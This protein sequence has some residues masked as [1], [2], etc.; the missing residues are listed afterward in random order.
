MG[1]H[2]TS[3]ICTTIYTTL[4]HDTHPIPRNESG[5]PMRRSLPP[6]L[7]AVCVTSVTLIVFAHL[8][9]TRRRKGCENGA[10][11]SE[12]VPQQDKVLK[13]GERCEK[14]NPILEGSQNNGNSTNSVDIDSMENEKREKKPREVVARLSSV[15]LPVVEIILMAVLVTLLVRAGA[16]VGQTS[17]EQVKS[18]ILPAEQV[19][20]NFQKFLRCILVV[21]CFTSAC[22]Q[23]HKLFDPAN[24][25]N[26]GGTWP[27]MIFSRLSQELWLLQSNESVG[28]TQRRRLTLLLVVLSRAVLGTVRS[29]IKFR[30][31]MNEKPEQNICSGAFVNWII[32]LLD[33]TANCGFLLGFT[34]GRHYFMAVEQDALDDPTA[35]SPM[36]L[37]RPKAVCSTEPQGDEGELS[38][39]ISQL[40]AKDNSLKAF[41]QGEEVDHGPIFL[42]YA[43]RG[44]L[45]LLLT[46]ALECW[47][48]SHWE[49][50]ILGNRDDEVDVFRMRPYFQSW[51]P[52]FSRWRLRRLI[53][54]SWRDLFY[55][56]LLYPCTAST[57]VICTFFAHRFFGKGRLRLVD[58]SLHRVVMGLM[59]YAVLLGAH[60]AYFAISCLLICWECRHLENRANDFARLFPELSPKQRWL[61]HF[62]LTNEVK[63]LQQR[64]APLI[65]YVFLQRLAY[66]ALDVARQSCDALLPFNLVHYLF[67]HVMV[68]T[69]LG[70]TAWRIGKLNFSIYEKLHNTVMDLLP[71]NWAE[72]LGHSTTL[73]QE[74]VMQRQHAEDWFRYLQHNIDTGRRDACICIF[75][76]RFAAKSHVLALSVLTLLTLPLLNKVLEYYGRHVVN[77]RL[78][79]PNMVDFMDRMEQTCAAS[80]EE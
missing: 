38:P 53:L 78:L 33:V 23:R 4:I 29:F 12:T 48:L 76:L 2:D 70:I 66:L 69:A 41:C 55:F 56:M 3:K 60:R 63:S 1:F 32:F 68:L 79:G 64:L 73:Q 37:Q 34:A 21:L 40:P 11:T 46:S 28:V 8:A 42:C 25:G 65:R 54:G 17:E 59:S 35:P 14:K 39:R 7:P 36:R 43:R 51:T 18:G 9:R 57:F 45:V 10:E 5:L 71:R 74:I 30:A 67:R 49:A 47:L 62:S 72:H 75:H 13:H 19:V 31:H 24:R 80:N 6:W 52:D 16:L 15:P 61:Q 26:P 20:W 58:S 77:D 22:L 27:N 50:G 44:L